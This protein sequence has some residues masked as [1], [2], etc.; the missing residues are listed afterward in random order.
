MLR[1]LTPE[2]LSQSQVPGRELPTAEELADAYQR[3]TLDHLNYLADVFADEE[4]R[5]LVN[6]AIAIQQR[7]ELATLLDVKAVRHLQGER[8]RARQQYAMA[9]AYLGGLNEAANVARYVGRVG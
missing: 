9:G 6:S 2:Q 1:D 3:A 8:A 5:G 4:V 7:A